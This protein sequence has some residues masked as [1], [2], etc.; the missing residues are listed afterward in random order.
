MRPFEGIRVLDMTH[1]LAGPFCTYQLALLGAE[2]T[3]VEPP[4]L[5]EYVR[6]RGA[7]PELKRRLMGD[8]FLCQNANKRSIAIDLKDRRGRDI[9]RR[10]AGQADVLV[11]N[12]RAGVMDR[13]GLGYDSLQAD[14]P[15]LIYC[16]LTAYGGTGPM[17]H[18]PGWDHTVAAASGMVAMTGTEDS[19]PLKAGTPVVDYSSGAM[20][21]FAVSAALFQ[22][23]RTG[24]GQRIDVSMLDT[25]LML[26]SPSIASYFAAGK[27][28]GPHG[29]SHALAAGSGYVTKDGQIIMLGA[30]MQRQFEEFCRRIGR[31][32][33]LEDP[34]FA[35]VRE[36]DP[37]RGALAEIL[38]EHMATRTAAEWENLLADLVP[39]V[40]VR[41]LDETLAFD[42]LDH[43]GVLHEL[44]P[45]D[46]VDGAL[47]T[48]VAAFTYAE[49][50]PRVDRAPPLLGA[51]TVEVLAGLGLT[52]DDIGSLAD[53]GVIEIADEREA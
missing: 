16:S 20:A 11:E 28:G 9:V 31:P 7:N 3:K 46:G 35:D 50:G 26:M 45:I 51:H 24:C 38:T 8:H 2:V 23:Q 52:A 15:R 53:D 21:A 13:L 36:Q 32:E 17:G 41:G 6:R 5:G 27:V 10:L 48:P 1:V 14:Y 19:G 29:N 42:Q 12:F 34:R 30:I 18:Q 39:A 43:R 40:R 49:D 25:A 37:H 33:L 22:R 47:K 4:G 44:E